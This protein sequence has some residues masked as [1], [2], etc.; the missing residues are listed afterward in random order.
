[1]ELE[2]LLVNDPL[3]ASLRDYS[4]VGGFSWSLQYNH[5]QDPD[6]DRKNSKFI[7][8]GHQFILANSETCFEKK[9]ITLK[10]HE[11]ASQF[12]SLFLER[13]LLFFGRLLF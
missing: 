3:M 8:K 2:L 6:L 10:P 4:E 12:L 1:M 7:F 5:H 11:E 13:M 9:G